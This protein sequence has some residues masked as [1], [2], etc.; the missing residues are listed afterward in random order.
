MRYNDKWTDY[1]HSYGYDKQEYDIELKNGKCIFN[2]YPN[3]GVF[4]SY[5]ENTRGEYKESDVSKIRLS[6]DEMLWIN[7]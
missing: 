7:E 2:C 5:N 6:K 4:T 3:A 1:D